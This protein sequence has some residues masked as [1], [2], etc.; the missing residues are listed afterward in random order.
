MQGPGLASGQGAD[1]DSVAH[2]GGA[3]LVEDAV[4]LEVEIGLAGLTW[5]RVLDKHPGTHQRTG[6]ARNQGIEQSLEVVV[7]GARD[8][9]EPG[10]V[11]LEGIGA[12]G[13]GVEI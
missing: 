3:Q 4:G 1:D 13:G 6:D 2:R 8:T 11:A 5:N 10:P 12:V 7:R 9:M